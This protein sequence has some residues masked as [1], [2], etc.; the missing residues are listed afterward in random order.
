MLKT[1]VN[2][3]PAASSF[4]ESLNMLIKVSIYFAAS[5]P[6][7]MH[8]EIETFPKLIRLFVVCRLV[9]LKMN[10]ALIISHLG[11]R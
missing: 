1:L 7:L 3:S 5:T 6:T 4:S 10:R 11:L 8:E 9:R 2:V